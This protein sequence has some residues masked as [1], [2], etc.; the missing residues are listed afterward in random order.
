[1]ID[2]L[3]VAV[4]GVSLTI[5]VVMG[6]ITWRVLSLERRRS[7]ERVS[8]LSA[9][10]VEADSLVAEPAMEVRPAA[11]SLSPAVSSSARVAARHADDDAARDPQWTDLV[12]D[13]RQARREAEARA[14]DVDLFK[15]VEPITSNGRRLTMAVALGSAMLVVAFGVVLALNPTHAAR[16]TA[17][18]AA[19][20]VASPLELVALDHGRTGTQFSIHGLV[21]NPD[22]GAAIADLMAVVFLFD[23]NG[24]YIG[25]TQ[26]RVFEP[27]L[28]PGGET[29]FTVPVT[30]GERVGRYRV[31]FRVASAPVPHIDRRAAAAPS[32][33]AP[34]RAAIAQR[35][36]M[37]PA[38][39][40]VLV[41]QT[42]RTTKLVTPA[43]GTATS[44][45][46]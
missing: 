46:R 41:A 43:V 7:A 1:M 12:L 6:V 5:A 42:G 4:T 19:A 31:S 35:A 45:G 33:R 44:F 11:R 38:S 36:A 20:H 32:D 30:G 34:V 8:D 26:A 39:Q 16:T 27:V 37:Q 24:G 22:G 29:A 40:A 10:A 3:L 15:E 18:P 21:R 9:A 25:T 23:R 28:A 2:I 13:R 14:V 17:S